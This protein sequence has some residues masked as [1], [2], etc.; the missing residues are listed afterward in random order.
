VLKTQTLAVIGVIMLLGGGCVCKDTLVTGYQTRGSFG[1]VNA[2]FDGP[3]TLWPK[4][5]WNDAAFGRPFWISIDEPWKAQRLITIE[6]RQGESIGFRRGFNG[7]VVAFAGK[8]ELTLPEDDYGWYRPKV[9]GEAVVEGGVLA[10]V[11]F[12]AGSVVAAGAVAAVGTAVVGTGG[13]LKIHR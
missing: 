8:S 2:Q 13:D 4:R 1:S 5:A 3:C 11:R 12:V 10:P 6:V 7:Q 9:G